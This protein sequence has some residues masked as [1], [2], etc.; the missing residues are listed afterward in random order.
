MSR[1]S[2][3]EP[4]IL[5]VHNCPWDIDPAFLRRFQKRIYVGLPNRNDRK[6]ILQK[7]L[8]SECLC[9]TLQDWE[10]I[11]DFT[12]G[13]SGADLRHV[14]ITTVMIAIKEVH[15]KYLTA[16]MSDQSKVKKRAIKLNDIEKAI[17]DNTKTVSSSLLD[18][19]KEFENSFR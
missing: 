12:D 6:L 11:L 5:S 9:L 13:Y 19:Y 14:V 1:D 7:Y 15:M 8:A 18:K 16:N 3:G 17:K 10:R 4:L 2:E